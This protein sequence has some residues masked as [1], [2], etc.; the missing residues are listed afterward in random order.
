MLQSEAM[1]QYTKQQ[2]PNKNFTKL[3]IQKAGLMTSMKDVTPNS[4]LMWKGEVLC[5]SGKG[6]CCQVQGPEFNPGTRRK[7]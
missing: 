6:A 5:L 1:S 3:E 7:D 2:T 4:K